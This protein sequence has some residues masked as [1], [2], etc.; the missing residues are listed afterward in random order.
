MQRMRRDRQKPAS[1]LVSALRAALEAFDAKFDALVITGVEVHA[2]NVFDRAPIAS[3]Q[4]LIGV[5]V[6]RGA[7]RDAV[8]ISDDQ[9]QMPGHRLRN[10][11][12]ES[13]AQVRCRVMR[14]IG[15]FI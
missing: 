10:P 3:P 7:Y 2:R 12:E 4:R 15:S 11:I 5:D 8:T 9:Q 1:E 14:A 13:A 6:E